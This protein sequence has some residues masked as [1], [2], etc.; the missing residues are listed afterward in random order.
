MD[1][2][3]LVPKLLPAP[4]KSFKNDP[5]PAQPTPPHQCYKP[6]QR[7]D[8]SR[9]ILPRRILPHHLRLH[10]LSYVPPSFPSLHFL[11]HHRCSRHFPSPSPPSYYATP[12]LI[13]SLTIRNYHVSRRRGDAVRDGQTGESSPNDEDIA[14]DSPTSS[15]L[16]LSAM[17]DEGSRSRWDADVNWCW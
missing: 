12:L 3:K 2:L 4:T 15:S 5:H 10:S 6:A 9:A 7:R 1:E 16:G 14:G 8:P 11:H 17:V 13:G